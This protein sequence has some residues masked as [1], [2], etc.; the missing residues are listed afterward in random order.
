M[1]SNQQNCRQTSRG[2][3][4]AQ[5]K[6]TSVYAGNVRQITYVNSYQ[7]HGECGCIGRTTTFSYFCPRRNTGVAFKIRRI[8]GKLLMSYEIFIDWLSNHNPQWTAY[9]TFM[10]GCL[11]MLD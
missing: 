2:K 6:S 8:L 1:S 10:S 5:K 4:S 11:V 9:H 7:H 3:I